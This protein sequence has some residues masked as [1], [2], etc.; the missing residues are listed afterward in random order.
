MSVVCKPNEA[1]MQSSYDTENQS[2]ARDSAADRLES[3]ASALHSRAGELPGGD[4]MRD[5]AHA[6][7]DKMR[8]AADYIRENAAGSMWAS[9]QRTVGNYPGWS[10]LT[11]G[12]LG[13]ILA[14][15]ISR[16]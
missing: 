16:D 12:A 14:R 9:A 6:T 5:A 3:A 4:T 13:F 10:L 8:R 11:A 1:H 7:A 2:T 15:L